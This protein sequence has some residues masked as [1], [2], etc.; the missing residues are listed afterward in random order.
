MEKHGFVYIWF[1]KK[2]R[3]YYVGSHWG[4][5][6]DSYNCSSRWM[7][8]ACRRRPQDFKRRIIKT[9]IQNREE[10]LREEHR[11]LSLIHDEEL[12]KKYYNLSKHHPGHWS[13]NPSK[14]KTVGEKIAAAPGR[15]EKIAEAHRGKKLSEET[16]EKIRQIRL[17]TTHSEET[18]VKIGKNSSAAR[19]YD[20]PEFRAKMSKAASN[21]SEEHRRKIS[22]NNKR[23]IAEGKIGMKGKKHSPETI[24]K[25][26]ATQQRL[27]HERLNT[28][29]NS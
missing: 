15:R 8:K 10:L 1:D 27:A 6:T 28:N 11:Y 21:R 22:E 14:L 3:R 19:D 2:H 17:G 7:R 25:M 24:A 29:K 4:R 23:L 9:G 13:T 20:S 5:E 18:K 16:K 12:G 26:K